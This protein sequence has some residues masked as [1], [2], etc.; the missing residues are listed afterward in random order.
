MFRVSAFN[1]QKSVWKIIDRGSA[2]IANWGFLQNEVLGGSI[3]HKETR[4]ENNN[5]LVYKL[6]E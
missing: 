1:N 4:N 6:V 2:G 5:G 3:S